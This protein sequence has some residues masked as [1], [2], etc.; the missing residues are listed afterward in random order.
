MGAVSWSDLRRGLILLLAIATAVASA[1]RSASGQAELDVDLENAGGRFKVLTGPDALENLD[2]A[3]AKKDRTRPPMEIFRAQF[4]PFDVLPFVKARQ[5]TTVSLEARSNYEVFEGLMQTDVVPMRG[6]TAGPGILANQMVFRRDARMPLAQQTRLSF[7]V[8]LPSIPDELPLELTQ[9]GAIRPV[10]VLRASV[11]AL[12]PHQMLVVVLAGNPNDYGAWT[13]LPSTTPASAERKRAEMDRERYYR[14]VIPQETTATF[15]PSHPMTWA[16][17]SHI[18]WDNMEPDA[19]TPAQQDA[20][21]D[22]LH[23]G[24]QLVIVGGASPSLGLLRESFLGPF[25]PADTGGTNALLEEDDL[26]PLSEAYPPARPDEPFVEEFEAARRYEEP[27]PIRPAPKRPVYFAGLRKREGVGAVSLPMG[28]DRARVLG[29]ERR[30]G[31]GRITMLSFALTDPALVAWPGFDTLVRRVVFRRPEERYQG[32][33]RFQPSVTPWKPPVASRSRTNDWN[34]A[35]LSGPELSWVRYAARDIGATDCPDFKPPIE[36]DVELP[37]APVAEWDDHATLPTRSRA[38]LK[39]ASGISIPGSNFIL[40]VILAYVIALVPL[41]WLVC[42]YLLGRREWAWV[43][44]PILSLAFAVG[45]ERAAA[46]DLG[47]DSAC[48]EIDVLEIQGGHTRAHLSRFASLYSTGRVGF[49]ISYP[50]DPT[51]VALPM[52]TGD[53]LRGETAAE[54]SWQSWPVPS[55]IGLQVQ[56]RSLRLFRAEQMVRLGGAIRFD[57]GADA[58]RVVNESGLELR[59]ASLIEVVGRRRFLLGTIAPNGSIGLGEPIPLLPPET[60]ADSDGD[61]EPETAL[62]EERWTDPEPLLKP[63][64]EHSEARPENGGEWRLVAWAAGVRPGQAIAPA[65]DR[66]R[67]LCLVVAHLRFNPPP[68]PAWRLYDASSLE[69]DAD[70]LEDPADPLPTPEVGRR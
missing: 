36:P 57:F 6:M 46:Y 34:Y 68:D 20:M 11:R 43:L 35:C 17:I 27:F 54:S 21:L 18:L 31:R 9:P 37:R 25:L 29:V 66:T 70:E 55:L 56:P 8:F 30:V 32:G 7:Q 44:V 40:K 62:D 14:M 16:S 59:D 38:A 49:T 24:G 41:N 60:S 23:W 42:R 58:V 39:V 53:E 5:W 4:A 3:L 69:P 48:D 1:G 45:V 50:E 61:D 64:R 26:R 28:D 10:E 33:A 63:L 47:F 52:A 13:K 22:W 15:L 65:V 12:E 67:G 2:E 51:A 19:L